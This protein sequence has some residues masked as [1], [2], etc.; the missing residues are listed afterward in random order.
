TERPVITDLSGQAYWQLAQ[1]GY[2]PVGVVGITT[3]M[4]VASSW[5]D[6]QV[7][8]SGNSLF[9][10][11]G[12]ANQELRDFTRGFYEAREVAM[13]HLNV[14][15]GRLGANGIVGVQIDEHTR[16]RE[17]EDANDNRHV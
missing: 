1:A 4:Y 17:Y 8:R 7:L 3:V 14:Q 2:R 9:S 13:S 11:A 12:R 6:G 10:M 5:S 16:E 15:A